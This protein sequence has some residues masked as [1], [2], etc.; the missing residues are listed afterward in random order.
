MGC[1]SCFTKAGTRHYVGTS[2]NVHK[3]LKILSCMRGL[4][5]GGSHRHSPT[6]GLLSQACALKHLSRSLFSCVVFSL[7]AGW[8]AH[9]AVLTSRRPKSFFFS[10]GRFCMFTLPRA[11]L[12]WPFSAACVRSSS[13]SDHVSGGSVG[14]C[15][16]TISRSHPSR[17]R[18]LH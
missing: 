11:L 9:S 18:A 14:M 3:Q 17:P 8:V 4:A 13:F 1:N 16:V 12:A 6:L 2:A 10:L 5:L 15:Y 7:P